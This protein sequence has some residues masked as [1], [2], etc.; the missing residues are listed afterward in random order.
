MNPISF[1]LVLIVGALLIAGWILLWT[2]LTHLRWTRFYER[3]GQ[4][5]PQ[6]PGWGWLRFYCRTVGA[7]FQIIWWLLVHLFEDRLRRPTGGITGPPLLCVHGFHMTGS[8]MWGIRRLLESRGRATRAVFLGAPYQ[9]AET[10]AKPLARALRDLQ[11]QF[12]AAGYDIVAHSMGGLIT[13]KVLADEP[14]LAAGVR[15]IVTLGTPHH[16]TGLLS[17]L[18]FGPV[19]RMMSRDSVFLEELPDFQESA[20]HAEVTTV[21]TAQDLVVYPVSTCHLPG[22]REVTLSG[23]GHLGLLTEPSAFEVIAEALPPLPR[24]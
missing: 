10:Y 3:L 4:Q 6:L 9:S 14:E 7:A 17:W 8:C 20:P 12:S 1:L 13:R 2:G 23:I 16:G 22:A 18:R 19:Y 5:A 24:A 21:A 11:S 15:R